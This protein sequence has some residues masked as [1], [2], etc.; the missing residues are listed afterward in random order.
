MGE[1]LRV[2]DY[3]WW[4]TGLV[5]I[6][7]HCLLLLLTARMGLG[8]L[9]S[10][11][12][13]IAQVRSIEGLRA[14]NRLLEKKQTQFA[15]SSCAS[16]CSYVLLALCVSLCLCD[17]LR[18]PKGIDGRRNWELKDGGILGWRWESEN[19][20]QGSPSSSGPSATRC[21]EQIK[22]QLHTDMRREKKIK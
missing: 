1:L 6:K 18:R 17:L 21:R 19:S 14:E 9:I 7:Q 13:I 11:L 15:A 16:E 2:S 3:K 20:P 4:T 10:E 5:I 8:S 12:L 22:K